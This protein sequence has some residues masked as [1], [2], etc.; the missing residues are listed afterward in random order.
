VAKRGRPC[1]TGGPTHWSRNPA[2]IATHQA[3]AFLELWLADAPVN[4]FIAMLWPRA[5][6]EC[7]GKRGKERRYTVPPKIKRKLCELAI[8]YV[9]ELRRR[10]EDARPEIEVSLQRSMSGAKAALRDRGWTDREITA[11][12]NKLSERARKRSK[13]QFKTPDVGTVLKIVTRHAP[14]GTL[15]R[16]AG[17]HV[18]DR[19]LAYFQYEE[20]MRNAWRDG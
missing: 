19:E 6:P 11:W 9:V 10:I 16:K 3:S 12:L 17:R 13:K 4:E 15:R 20:H 14:A 5:S 2:N 1:G 7:W 18:D 8:T